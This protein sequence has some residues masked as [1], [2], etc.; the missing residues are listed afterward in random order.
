MLEFKSLESLKMN[1]CQCV[2]LKGLQGF[3]ILLIIK[4]FV[5]LSI[6]K[7]LQVNFVLMVYLHS[8]R[9]YFMKNYIFIMLAFK[10]SESFKIDPYQCIYKNVSEVSG[11]LDN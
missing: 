5:I 4:G 8:G 11:F 6:I 7:G 2:F 1:P 10:S 3:V 9:C